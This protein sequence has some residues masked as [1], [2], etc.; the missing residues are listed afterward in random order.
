[1]LPG[2][3]GAEAAACA[4][5]TTPLRQKKQFPRREVA[6]VHDVF[7]TFVLDTLSLLRCS[8]S[9]GLEAPLS[10][11]NVPKSRIRLAETLEPHHAES[12]PS[13][14]DIAK[15]HGEERRYETEDDGGECIERDGACPAESER[16]GGD[17]QREQGEED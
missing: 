8:F 15:R 2:I 11:G 16:D 3:V 4:Y 12:D 9:R 7:F 6:D 1:M 14:L 5:L 10:E 17:N 13:I